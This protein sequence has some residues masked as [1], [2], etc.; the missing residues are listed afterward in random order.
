MS[1]AFSQADLD[2]LLGDLGSP[3]S[4]TP[5][6]VSE[7]DKLFRDLSALQEQT[8][9]PAQEPCCADP[10]SDGENLSQD[11]IDELLKQFLG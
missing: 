11:Q 4:E 6:E 7:M 3:S 8:P 5:A 1:D 2:A 10:P 9:A